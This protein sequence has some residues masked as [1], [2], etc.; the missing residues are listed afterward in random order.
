MFRYIWFRYISPLISARP[1]LDLCNNWEAA[2]PRS[3]LLFDTTSL[4]ARV[5]GKGTQGHCLSLRDECCFQLKKGGRGGAICIV[6]CSRVVNDHFWI[7]ITCSCILLLLIFCCYC[8]F[9]YLSAATSKLFLSEP[10]I[11]AFC[12]KSLPPH[13]EWKTGR[14][15]EWEKCLESL[16]GGTEFGSTVPK[17]GLHP[18]TI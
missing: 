6:H 1:G 17:A 5:G 4:I 9:S 8:S 18:D 16:S 10:M 15:S 7:W 3:L 13:R 14:G 11:L 12:A 2:W